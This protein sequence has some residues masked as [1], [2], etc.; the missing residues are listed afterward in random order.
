MEH[1]QE[2]QA[3]GHG[4][5]KSSS[6]CPSNDAVCQGLSVQFVGVGEIIDHDESTPHP[7]SNLTNDHEISDSED[8][9]GDPKPSS[10]S[11][12]S[13]KRGALSSSEYISSQRSRITD[14]EDSIERIRI[15]EKCSS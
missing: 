13:R 1:E 15:E 3:Q 14:S 12:T 7:V 10:S 5:Q 2:L 8:S 4:E 9:I 11:K 6:S